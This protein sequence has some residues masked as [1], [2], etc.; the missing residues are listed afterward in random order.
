MFNGVIAELDVLVRCAEQGLDDETADLTP[1]WQV[2]SRPLWQARERMDGGAGSVAQQ[3]GWG[4][5]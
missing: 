1:A 2:I 5:V 4:P 3:Q